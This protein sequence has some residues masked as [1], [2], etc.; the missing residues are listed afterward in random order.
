[1]ALT[2]HIH[3][4]R[5]KPAHVRER[6]AVLA[7]GSITALVAVGWVVALGS[8][9]SLA[10]AG[11]SVG[12]GVTPPTEVKEVFTEGSSQFSNMLG[13]AGAAFGGATTSSSVQVVD[14]AASS[15][16]EAA[17]EATVIPF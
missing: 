6:I 7:S 1:M 13:A 3:S 10:V 12:E 16:L 8:S 15:T 2:E 4:L 17:E 14:V 5:Q 9:G 11:K